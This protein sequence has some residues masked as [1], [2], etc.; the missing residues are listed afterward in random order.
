MYDEEET[1]FI[2]ADPPYNIKDVLYGHKGNMHKQFDHERFA[3][4]VEKCL[5]QVMISYNDLL[6]LYIDLTSGVCMITST[7]T[8]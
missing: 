6:T 1:T 7:L 5:C 3:D 4:M 8:Q 2:Y